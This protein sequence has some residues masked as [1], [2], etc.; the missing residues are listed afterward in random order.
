MVTDPYTY[1]SN[2]QPLPVYG[3]PGDTFVSLQLPFGSF[4]P[5]QPPATITINAHL[6]DYADAGTS[7]D[8]HSIAR[9]C[10][11]C[12]AVCDQR[13][14]SHI[15]AGPIQ[16]RDS[17][18][19]TNAHSNAGCAVEYTNARGDEYVDGNGGDNKDEI[20]V[21]TYLYSIILVAGYWY[22]NPITV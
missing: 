9:H 5:G 3:T 14:D 7:R 16:D 11:K 6:S 2:G 19:S 1:D 15:N 18:T 20:G 13:A 17:R 8:A 12:D 10:A 4:L 22:N 21:D